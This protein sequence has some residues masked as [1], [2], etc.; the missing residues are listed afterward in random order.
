M[1]LEIKAETK[2]ELIVKGGIA[3][4]AAY[5]PIA[6]EIILVDTSGSTSANLSNFI[7]RKRCKPL[8][9]LEEYAVYGIL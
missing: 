5:Q 9:P 4:L 7:Y 2:Q 3:L 6:S 8:Y 1:N